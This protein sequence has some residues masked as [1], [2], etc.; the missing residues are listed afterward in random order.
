MSRN[1]DPR[2]GAAVD[3]AVPAPSGEATPPR[4]KLYNRW[5]AAKEDR[6]FEALAMTANVTH[7]ATQAGMTSQ[8]AHF[9]RHKCPAFAARWLS[10]LAEGYSRLEM[11]M[12]DHAL[13]GYERTE[14]VTGPDGAVK[15][16]KTV[17]SFPHVVAMQLLHSHREAAERYRTMEAMRGNG[18]PELVNKI[19]A[20]LA[21]VR[22][23]L[24]GSTIDGA[25]TMRRIAE[26]TGEG[27][28]EE[29]SGG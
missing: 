3:M 11:R 10:A 21:R 2:D 6:F 28:Q 4:R 8:S 1:D 23:R 24:A 15:Q 18:D 14:T 12:L 26:T 22:A 13:N 29:S 9:R 16:V 19:R 20:E 7:A 27:G 25:D 17:H 5:S